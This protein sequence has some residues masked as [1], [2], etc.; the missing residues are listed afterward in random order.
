[1]N[2]PIYRNTIGNKGIAIW[3]QNSWTSDVLRPNMQFEVKNAI[4]FWGDNLSLRVNVTGR[5]SKGNTYGYRDAA[6]VGAANA[7]YY[8]NSEKVSDWVPSNNKRHIVVLFKARN[9]NYYQIR[10]ISGL[11]ESNYINGTGS[12]H[13]FTD[14]VNGY[15]QMI[16]ANFL[17]GTPDKVQFRNNNNGGGMQYVLGTSS[18]GTVYSTRLNISPYETDPNNPY[19]DGGVSGPGGGDG[20]FSDDSD[21]IIMNDMPDES[22]CSSVGS[23]FSTIFTPSKSQLKHLSE[24]MWGSTVVGFFQNMVENISSMFVSLAIVPFSVPAG[25]TVSVQWLGLIDTAISLTLASNQFLTFNMGSIN[26]ASDSRVFSSGSVLDYSPFSKLGI[27][28]PFIGFQELD[29][30]ECRDCTISLEYRVDIMSGSCVAIIFLNGD[31]IYQFSGN[32]VTQIPLTSQD[33][34]TLFTNAVNIG[35]AASAAGTAGAV[36][37]AGDSVTAGNYESGQISASQA[38]LEAGQHAMMVERSMGSLASATANGMMGMKPSYK[39]AGAISG[40][41]SLLALT[42]PY[43]FLTTPRQSLPEHYQK[44]CGFPSNITGTLGSFS[45]FTV[46]EDI[47]LN[48]LVATAPEVEEI[49]TLLKNGIII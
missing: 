47:R 39:K 12:S 19:Y 2:F 28:L 29:I 16:K 32:C 9:A 10:L 27:Y 20:N 40:S 21:H 3:D 8:V 13:I 38:E 44:Y 1:M 11:G 41:N 33:T 43:L 34:Q 42:Q 18:P 35:I 7:G 5:D 30:D 6:T 24:I 45:G 48:G 22:V 15:G 36:A 14:T 31:P 46:V 26:M 49:Y 4:L 23:G 17:T 37:S 25:S